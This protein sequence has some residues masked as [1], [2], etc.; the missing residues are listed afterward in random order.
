M[1]ISYCRMDKFFEHIHPTFPIFR[2]NPVLPLNLSRT[3]DRVRSILCA[4]S[5]KVLGPVSFWSAASADLLLKELMKDATIEDSMPGDPQAL[6]SF[7]AACLL[8]FYGFHQCPGQNTW[9]RISLLTRKAYQ[10]ELHQIDHGDDISKFGDKFMTEDEIEDWK[11]VWWCIYCLDSYSS[12]ST[13]TPYLV[14]LESLNTSLP[15]PLTVSSCGVPREQP[16][17]LLLSPE[18]SGLWEITRRV[19]KRGGITTSKSILS[20][21]P[22]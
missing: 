3:S 5:A 22:S 18:I 4:M 6:D 13:G 11:Q 19:V 1:L 10:F 20:Q 9:M 14:E 17:P 12:F 7:R 16:N 2:Y 15:E 8:A 21:P